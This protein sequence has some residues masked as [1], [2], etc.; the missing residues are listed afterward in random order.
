[1]CLNYN[2]AK[3]YVFPCALKKH[4]KVRLRGL[5]IK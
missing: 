5:L 3:E 2:F 1:M 4:M